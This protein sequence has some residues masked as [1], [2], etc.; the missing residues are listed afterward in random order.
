M[1]YG[2]ARVSTIEQNT[3]LQITALKNAGCE[4]VIQEHRSAVKQRP[5][6]EKLLGELVKGDVLIVYK[7]DRLA[8]S[9]KNLIEIVENLNSRGVVLQSLTE[10]INPR[11]AAGRMFMQV[12]GAVAEFERSL[13]RERTMAGQLEALKRGRLIGRPS[14]IPWEDQR[15]IIELIG[16]GW[17]H[18]SVAAAYGVSPSRALALYHEATGRKRRDWGVLRTLY[19]D[20]IVPNM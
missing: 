12:L 16:A 18:R 4:R 14:R 20:N 19:Y 3:S 13:I 1:K 5:E 7:L 6:L 2:Y 11:T 17:P 10:P 9:L 8:R 15:E